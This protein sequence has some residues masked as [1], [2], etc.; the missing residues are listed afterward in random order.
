MEKDNIDALAKRALAER[1]EL[2]RLQQ[3]ISVPD[4]NLVTQ[5]RR[6][7]LEMRLGTSL[8][9]LEKN[10]LDFNHL[11]GRNVE[12][13]VGSVAVPVGVVGPIPLSGSVAQGD[14][15]LPLA[16]TE[17]ALVAS[18]NRGAKAVRESGRIQAI[19]LR[20]A[21]TRAPAFRTEAAMDAARL[22][23]W[24]ENNLPAMQKEAAK[25]TRHG[26]L[27]G[28]KCYI[29]GNIA[30][31]RLSFTTGDAMG[32]NMAT[33]ASEKISEL[34]EKETGAE[35][36]ALSGNL[37]SDKKPAMINSLL[38]RGKSV[39]AETL[40]REASVR[41]T[42][43][44][45]AQRIV[46]VNSIKNQTGSALAGSNSQNAHFANILA[47]SFIATGQDVAQIVESSQGFTIAEERRGDLY[48]SVTL[49]SLEVGATGG[50]TGLPTQSELINLT[51]AGLAPEGSRA[52]WLAEVIAAG[53]LCGE[54]SL[55]SA[56]A[57]N[58]L[59]GSHARLGRAGKVRG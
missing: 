38:G 12:N 4:E 14:V 15:Y 50:G 10:P 13:P 29:V 6:R 2:H 1:I 23:A 51:G 40:I 36:V 24:V 56:I 52:K 47:A 53:V 33:I 57:A 35:L 26:K 45:T 16:T 8:S 31:V 28:A 39:I 58:Q 41:D 54:L 22:E 34:I 46:R 20:D 19:V 9:S 49:P 42:L 48:F 3:L 25:T 37:C 30:Y 11:V 27:I 7:V 32:M 21:M 5:L 55:L 17:G 43:K 44:T 59:A 18:T